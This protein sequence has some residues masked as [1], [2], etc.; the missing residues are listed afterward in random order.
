MIKPN[1]NSSDIIKTFVFSDSANWFL[2]TILSRPQNK[3]CNLKFKTYILVYDNNK[4]H[5]SSTWRGYF[6]ILKPII[7][8]LC[9]SAWYVTCVLCIYVSHKATKNTFVDKTDLIYVL[10]EL[11][12]SV[13]MWW[14]QT[15]KKTF[16]TLS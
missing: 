2:A 8:T 4:S 14:P 12:C 16:K 3:I 5:F 9:R 1:K 7:H 15:Q 6:W 10:R 13:A 11:N